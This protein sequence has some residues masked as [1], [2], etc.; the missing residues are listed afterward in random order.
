[1]YQSFLKSFGSPKSIPGVFEC[2]Y[3]S[4]AVL[5][6]ARANSGDFAKQLRAAK[7]EGLKGPISFTPSGDVQGMLFE[8]RQ[9]RGGLAARL[10]Y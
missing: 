3:D 4:V 1:M 9:I 8:L 2:A 10:E 5:K 7:I 6:T